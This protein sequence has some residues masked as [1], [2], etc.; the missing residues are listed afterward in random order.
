MREGFSGYDPIGALEAMAKQRT[1]EARGAKLR[2]TFGICLRLH[3]QFGQSFADLKNRLGRGANTATDM[4]HL[5]RRRRNRAFRLE[6]FGCSEE[7][8]LDG[9]GARLDQ[10]PQGIEFGFLC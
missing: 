2:V 5:E 6:L 3:Q 4:I 1:A 10:W 9:G 8:K 7:R